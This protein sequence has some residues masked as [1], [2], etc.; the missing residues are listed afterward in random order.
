MKASLAA[1]VF[2]VLAAAAA[3]AAAQRPDMDSRA[4]TLLSATL[5]ASL[6]DYANSR[7]RDVRAWSSSSGDPAAYSACGYIDAGDGRGGRWG[8]TQ[9]AARMTISDRQA[10]ARAE[11]Y[12][13]NAPP[14]FR[15]KSVTEQIA[16]RTVISTLCSADYHA[17]E[18]LVSPD[19]SGAIAPKAR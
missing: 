8:W 3:P 14:Q 4:A 5:G 7:F 15:A 10:R 16:D 12:Y 17:G 11:L 6:V 13:E 2:A 19:W 18:R 9:F 1:S